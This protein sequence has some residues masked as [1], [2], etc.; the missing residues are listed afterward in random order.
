MEG[1][2]LEAVFDAFVNILRVSNL[3]LKKVFVCLFLCLLNSNKNVTQLL[4]I[5]CTNTTSIANWCPAIRGGYK[6]VLFNLSVPGD[7]LW[8]D[9]KF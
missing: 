8:M 4:Q 5:F 2:P 6:S 3:S 7:E 1:A 9:G